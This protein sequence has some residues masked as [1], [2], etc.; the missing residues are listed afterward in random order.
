M[1]ASALRVFSG[2][3]DFEKDRHLY[4]VGE[5]VRIGALGLGCYKTHENLYFNNKLRRELSKKQKEH[6]HKAKSGRERRLF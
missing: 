1:R 2:L 6:T 5:R 3:N 4:M